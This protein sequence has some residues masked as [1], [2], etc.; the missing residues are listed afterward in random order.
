MFQAHK[1]HTPTVELAYP[2]T[3]R[4]DQVEATL[5]HLDQLWHTKDHNG[6]IC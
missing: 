3:F 2:S 6:E 1:T 4:V 5:F